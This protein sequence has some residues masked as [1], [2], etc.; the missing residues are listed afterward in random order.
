MECHDK[1]F[2]DL[3]ILTKEERVA[4][5][6]AH[7]AY[8]LGCL[9]DLLEFRAKEY[10]W[11]ERDGFQM[12]PHP[13]GEHY[14]LVLKLSQDHALREKLLN[15][16]ETKMQKVLE[17]EDLDL[18]ASLAGI[19]STSKRLAYGEQWGKITDPQDLPFERMMEVRVLS[20]ME[21]RLTKSALAR[22]LGAEKIGERMEEL[23]GDSSFLKRRPDERLALL[24]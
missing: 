14:M 1:K 16:V 19:L 7:R 5:E 22:K 13:F 21:E 17:S 3:A 24:V 12:R 11:M 8:V 9:F 20:E 6:E 2:P 23:G 18:V 10:V 4:L 15:Q